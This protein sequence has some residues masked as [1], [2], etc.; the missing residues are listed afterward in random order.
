[1]KSLEKNVELLIEIL[2]HIL[3]DNHPYLPENSW[4]NGYL[5]GKSTAYNFVLDSLRSFL[6][7][8]NQ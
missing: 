2:E 7:S 1:M 6:G 5:A 4:I 3:S 8:S